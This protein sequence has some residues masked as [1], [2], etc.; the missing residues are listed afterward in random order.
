MLLKT[1]SHDWESAV[2]FNEDHEQFTTM[3]RAKVVGAYKFPATTLRL[4]F[5]R[6]RLIVFLWSWLVKVN[7]PIV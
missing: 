1:Q 7:S 3:G 6:A 5:I 4:S 2:H